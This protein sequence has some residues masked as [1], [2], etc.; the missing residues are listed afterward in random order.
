MSSPRSWFLLVLL[1]CL[2]AFGGGLLS[3]WAPIPEK[4]ERTPEQIQAARD[5]L[6]R[7]RQLADDP[8]TENERLWK[9]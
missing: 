8:K 1:L 4:D 9:L 6:K 3:A 7:L 5:D 2:L